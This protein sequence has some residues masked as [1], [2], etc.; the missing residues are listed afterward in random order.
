MSTDI[1]GVDTG[2][3]STLRRVLWALAI[4]WLLTTAALAVSVSWQAAAGS[5]G[6][7]SVIWGI[8]FVIFPGRGPAPEVA[9]DIEN[10]I[11]VFRHC[12]LHR[13]FW[14]FPVQPEHTCR[15]SDILDV[16]YM[17]NPGGHSTLTVVTTSGTITLRDGLTNFAEVSDALTA[18]ARTTPAGPK[19]ENP[20]VLTAVAIV[21]GFA[22]V[23][24]VALLA[25][26]P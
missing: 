8:V 17:G 24:A 23:I 6:I 12:R 21:L 11:V 20:W 4:T 19:W 25:D 5:L 1:K 9:I 10:R 14:S 13:S 3:A 7:V 16:H 18:I 26:W 15:F 22:V 2:T